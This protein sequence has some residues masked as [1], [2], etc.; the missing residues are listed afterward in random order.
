MTTSLDFPGPSEEFCLGKTASY[1]VAG[2]ETERKGLWVMT[3]TLCLGAQ[4]SLQG[5]SSLAET[6]GQENLRNEVREAFG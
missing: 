2:I 3:W 6:Q 4:V 1:F 5:I